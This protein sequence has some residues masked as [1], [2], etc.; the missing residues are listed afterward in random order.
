MKF[1]DKVYD[2]LKWICL[3]FLPAF[4]V[5]LATVL[6]VCGVDAGIV[7]IICVVLGA[8]ETFIGALIGVSTATYKAEQ[9][10]A[11]EKVGGTD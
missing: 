5:L 4:G 10:M 2:A 8:V 7:K 3:I 1:P 6:P 9:A 11:E